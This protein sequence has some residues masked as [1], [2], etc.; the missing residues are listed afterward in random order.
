MRIKKLHSKSPRA[1]S[2]YNPRRLPVPCWAIGVPAVEGPIRHLRISV[3]VHTRIQIHARAARR[4]LTTR[5]RAVDECEA[6]CPCMMEILK[7]LLC[8]EKCGI[9]CRIVATQIHPI[10]F[11]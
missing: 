4:K 8:Y 1:R 5:S 11:P 6:G 9:H 7:S 2:K 10:E 3:L